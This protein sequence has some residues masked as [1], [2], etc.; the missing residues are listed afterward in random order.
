[1]SKSQ[2]ASILVVDD[3]NTMLRIVRNLLRQLGFRHVDEASDAKTA[4]AKDPVCGMSVDPATAKHSAEHDGQTYYFCSAGCRGKF[5]AEPARFLAAAEGAKE[6]AA[7][8][9]HAM[10][11]GHAMPHAP[12]QAKPPHAASESA[13]STGSPVASRAASNT[14]RTLG[15]C[16][17]HEG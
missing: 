10:A 5:V 16:K 9:A 11:H 14:R 2:R 8:R 15:E 13:A 1:M 12:A 7:E 17:V 4:L 6:P 3:Y